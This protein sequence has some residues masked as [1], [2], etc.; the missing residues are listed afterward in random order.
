MNCLW[1]DADIIQAVTWKTIILP[2]EY[3][4][5]CPPCEEQL[6]LIRGKRCRKCSRES[7]EKLCSDC[8]WREQTEGESSLEWN[9]SVFT[10]NERM[11]EMVS[12]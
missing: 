2:P 10:Y 6:Q 4:N 5:L 12:K 11:Q 1:C 8:R 7:E 3:K 9:Y